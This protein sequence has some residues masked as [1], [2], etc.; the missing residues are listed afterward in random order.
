MTALSE[1]R[2]L[3]VGACLSLSGRYSPFGVQAAQG[4]AAWSEL[5]GH[6]ELTVEDDASSP[7][8]LIACLRSLIRRCDLVLGPYSTQ[9]M[10]AAASVAGELDVVIWNHGGSGDDVEAS[11][12]GR[13]VSILTPT[14]RYGKPFLEHLSREEA[15]AVLW[16]AEGRGSFGRQV[17]AG[18]ER[19]ADNLG[20][21]TLRLGASD[22]L[23][24][25]PA[26]EEWD[27]LCA[28]LFEEDVARV[29]RVH[30]LVQPPRR[31]AAVAAGVQRFGEIVTRSEG[32]FGIAQWFPGASTQPVDLGPSER[33]F[34]S[35]FTR[36]TGRKPDYPAVQ[37]AAGAVIGTHCARVAGAVSCKSL[38]QVA[39][40]LEAATLFGPFRIDPVT[41]VQVGHETVLVQ[42][43]PEGL[44]PTGSSGDPL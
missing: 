41:G 31:V 8:R 37:A 42:W 25:D 30:S 36:L 32:V 28:G 26:A 3:R 23:P 22:A 12:P 15:P 11:C 13:V 38:W 2:P 40:P 35:A 44:V 39:A 10:R 20:L 27:L 19:M 34:L 21:R 7:D 29:E 1:G 4:L 6:A 43:T 14:S 9:L 18:A 5:D 17:A 24:A 16:L 33:D